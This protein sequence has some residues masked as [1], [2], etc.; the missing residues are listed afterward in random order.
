MTRKPG[1]VEM[2]YKDMRVA[3]ARRLHST[4]VIKHTCAQSK[5]YKTVN[6]TILYF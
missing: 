5:K 6:C 1:S 2:K 3:Q 4:A